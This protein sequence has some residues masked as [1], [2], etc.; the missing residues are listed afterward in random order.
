M[1][2]ARCLIEPG[3][4]GYKVRLFSSK[5]KLALNPRVPLEGYLSYLGV[6]ISLAIALPYLAILSI[7]RHSALC[8]VSPHRE[9][10]CLATLD[11][12]SCLDG[13]VRTA[14]CT[15][16][17]VN[18][19]TAIGTAIGNN[20]EIVGRKVRVVT[21]LPSRQPFTEI[22]I[23]NDIV[24]CDDVD[25]IIGNNFATFNWSVGLRFRNMNSDERKQQC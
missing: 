4:F 21:G 13:L 1:G 10:V 22:R 7:A 5:H 20:L 9:Y 6:G 3:E 14:S 19:R 16:E 2:K 15:T 17:S 11:S 18:T 12:P 24:A 25:T 8:A 23:W